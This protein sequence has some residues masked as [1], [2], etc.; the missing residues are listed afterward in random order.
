MKINNISFITP[1]KELYE[2]D[3]V[4]E[5]SYSQEFRL[6][7]GTEISLCSD[8]G[9]RKNQEDSI[10]ITEKNG[11][12]LLLVADG[13]GGMSYGELASY[14][15]A[16][17]IKNWLE[18]E[19]KNSLKLL[20]K[21]SLEDVLNALIYLISTKIPAYCGSTLNMSIVGPKETLIANIGDSR[22]YIVKD[23]KLS[24]LTKD[25]S[26][27]FKNY[28]P[29]TKEE[30]EKLRFHRK[31]NV[32]MNSINKN[33]FPKIKIITINNNDYD[34]LCHLTDG[35][36]DFLSESLIKTYIQNENPSSLLVEKSVA[37][38][39]IHSDYLGSEFRNII[40]P[41][42]DN[43]TA[44]VYTKKKSRITN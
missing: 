1:I 19:D 7:N 16:K 23:G 31:N 22:T 42:Q 9:K 15:T 34:I 8:Q 4:L 14:T 11:Y 39:P 44:I 25:D 10:A 43:A 13:M 27:V 26:V 12:L 30:R 5:K 24:L 40:Y 21:S 41:G 29:R 2:T 6:P 18:T 35:V 17:T 28:N 32:I 20:D 37:G 33:A 36:S 38:E 3:I